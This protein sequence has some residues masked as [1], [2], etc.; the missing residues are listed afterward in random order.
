MALQVTQ[1]KTDR[2][3]DNETLVERVRAG[4]H[5]AMQSLY[6]RFVHRITGIS[7]KLLRHSADIEDVVQ[8]TF[9]EA[10][11]DIAQLKEPRYV[12]RW[13][14]GIA[15]HRIHR[16]FRTRKMKR[17]LGPDRS[18]DNELLC[19]QG[20]WVGA[21]QE[22]RAELALL[23]AAFDTM[24]IVDRTC[25]VLRFFEGYQLKE[26]ADATDKSLATVKRCIARAQIIVDRHFEESRHD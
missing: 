7:A 18:I 5:W 25:F 11:R 26:V 14:V 20:A 17:R 9:I 2:L 6:Q 22:A 12:E 24:R 3:V 16:R 13:L 23:D 8:D 10:Y 1:L 4:D 19:N 21:N 15:I